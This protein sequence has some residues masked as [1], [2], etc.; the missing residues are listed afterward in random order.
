M[1]VVVLD[2]VHDELLHL[3]E[4]EEGHEVGQRGDAHDAV[5]LRQL[6]QQ[7]Q[8]GHLRRPPAP[9]RQRPR[10]ARVTTPLE[11]E[12]QISAGYILW[13]TRHRRASSR[14][15]TNFIQCT[16]F[17]VHQAPRTYKG[18]YLSLELYKAGGSVLPAATTSCSCTSPCC[19]TGRPSCMSA[20]ARPRLLQRALVLPEQGVGHRA[21]GRQR[22]VQALQRL[23]QRRQPRAQL[24]RHKVGLQQRMDLRA[25]AHSNVACARG[26]FRARRSLHHTQ[27]R[28]MARSR[29]GQQ[30]WHVFT[31]S[32]V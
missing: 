13:R 32:L 17:T 19:I 8:H 27:A 30:V 5:H 25:A 9:A 2:G 23:Q 10:H 31:D 28:V 6:L 16:L 11:L 14:I 24:Q 29:L 18:R 4:A 15:T 26:P 12:S 1:Q 20:A 21:G 22:L 7:A 3:A